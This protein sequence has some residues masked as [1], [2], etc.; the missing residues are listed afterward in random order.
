MRARRRR[1]GLGCDAWR[2][3]VSFSGS[4]RRRLAWRSSITLDSWLMSE[5]SK[6]S[7][8]PVGDSCTGCTLVARREF[9]RDAA[10]LAAAALVALGAAPSQAAASVIGLVSPIG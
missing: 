5:S 9:F 10:A 8:T 4:R 6:H 1:I 3:P 2:S 7:E